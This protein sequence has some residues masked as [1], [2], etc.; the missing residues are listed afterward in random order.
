MKTIKEAAQAVII[1]W[2]TNEYLRPSIE[3]LEKA[4][5]RA[6]CP[7]CGQSMTHRYPDSSGCCRTVVMR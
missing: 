6:N 3:E 1:A 5:H 2:K 7:K 4:L